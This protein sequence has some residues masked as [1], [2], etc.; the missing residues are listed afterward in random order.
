MKVETRQSTVKV[1]TIMKGDT[2]LQ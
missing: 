2:H 1:G